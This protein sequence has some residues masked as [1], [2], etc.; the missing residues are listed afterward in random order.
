MA[1]QYVLAGSNWTSETRVGWNR[2][3]LDRLNDFWMTIDPTVTGEVELTDPRGASGCSP[4]PEG[5]ATPTSEV[6][7]MRGRSWSFEQKFS[8][9]VSS[10]TLKTGFRWGREGGSKTNPQNPNFSFQNINDLLANVPNSTNL[11]SGQPAHDAHLDSFGGFLQ[12]D[13]RVN[14][15]LVLNLGMRLDFY[16]DFKLK[17][18][19]DRPA[20]IVNLESPTDLRLMDFG[21]PRAPDD[22]YNPDWFNVGPRAGFAWTLDD[23]V[24]P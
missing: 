4:W 16:P 12:D 9:I 3:A 2:S 18:T 1:G 8:R 15:R 21:A 7:A 23:A 22:I 20:E 10:H 19:S 24:R 5:F 17:A 13:W 14:T 6:L 11:Q